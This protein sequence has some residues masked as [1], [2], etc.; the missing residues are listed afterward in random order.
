MFVISRTKQLRAIIL[1]RFRPSLRSQIA[2]LGI[3]GVVIVSAAC[4]GGLEYA[5]RMQRESDDSMRFRAQLS[6]LSDG[7]L[8]TQQIAAKF[9]R[10]RNEDLAKTLA[11]RVQDETAMLDRLEAF[12]AALPEDDPIRQVSSLRSGIN[13]YATR[14]QNIVGAQRMLGLTDNDGLRGKLRSSAQ[15]YESRLAQLDQPGLTVLLLTMRRLEKDFVL[16]GEE[17]FGDQLDEREAA[18]ETALASSTLAKD[19]KSELLGLARSYKL[20]FAG[21][22]VSRQALDDQ[23]EDLYQIFDRIRPMLVRVAAAASARADLAQRKASEFRQALTWVIGLTAFVLTLFAVLFGRRLAGLISRM[24]A[25]MRQLAD[26][27]FDVVLPG[28]ERSDEI[29][30]MARAVESFKTKAQE[31]ARLELDARLEENRRAADRHKRELARLAEAFEASAGGVIDTVSAASEEL[32]ASARDLSDTAHHTQDMSANVAAASE[33]ASDNV[34]RVAAA[35]EQMI[36]SAS[37]IGRQVEESAS[38]ASE[39]VQ[40]TRQTDDRMAQ[41]ASAADRI[42]NVVQLI[43]T[44]AHQTNPLAL[45]ATIEAARAGKAGSGFAVVAQE[46]KTL[47]RRTAEATEE[48]REQIAGIQTA[49]KESAE[50]ISDIAG[51]IRRISEIASGVAK[52]IEAQGDATRSIAQNVQVASERTSQVAVSIGQVASGASRTGSASSQVLSSARLLSDGNNRL[53]QEL[54]NFIATIRAG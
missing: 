18:F 7:F 27:R 53:K 24:T 30:E 31:K 46:V 38:I 47:A 13:L 6:E 11:N 52:A 17:R 36:A 34:R 48:I 42:G 28:L 8:E 21:V 12:A 32:A 51:I 40:Q 49:T 1:K 37:E 43:A 23:M 35:A 4:L 50:A 26:G 54:D 9:L 44:I 25:A 45:N 15:Q 33:E 2:M 14:F 29:G 22:L 20:A 16:S 3:G 5:A 10:T 41:L 39:A 19:V